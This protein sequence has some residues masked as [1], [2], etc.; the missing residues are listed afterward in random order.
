MDAETHD[1]AH[2]RAFAATLLEQAGLAP[3]R[4]AIVA[5]T[6]VEGDML[7][8]TTHGLAQLPGY[9][10]ALTDGSMRAEGEPEVVS[11]RGGT[12]LLDG[13]RLPGPF[14]VHHAIDLALER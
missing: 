13:R 9:L 4:A 5:G 10:G 1:E 8:H 14:L 2:L 12:L 7:G 3:D 6:L 11:D